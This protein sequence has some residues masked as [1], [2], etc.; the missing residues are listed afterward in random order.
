VDLIRQIDQWA[1]VAPDR[2]A[3]ASEGRTLTYGELRAQSDAL[4]SW[5]AERLG[6]DRTPVAVIG[7]KEPE[8]LIA[9]LGVVK[10]GRPYVPID[11]SIPPQRAERIVENAKATL[12]L[13]P[14]VVRDILASPRVTA[15]PKASRSPK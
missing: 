2:A 1:D 8:M 13:T 14:V 15:Q 7:H 10:S 5:L 4:A 6:E 11:T 9:F 12:T 3:H